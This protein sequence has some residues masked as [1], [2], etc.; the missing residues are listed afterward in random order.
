MRKL[1]KE[2]PITQ[3]KILKEVIEPL[4]RSET[5]SSAIFNATM[6]NLD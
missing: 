2:I 4:T 3:D 1:L 5:A 6:R